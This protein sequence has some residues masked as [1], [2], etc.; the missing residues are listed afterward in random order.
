MPGRRTRSPSPD[1]SRK[2]SKHSTYPRHSPSP[3]RRST[4]HARGHD[5][6]RPRDTRDTRDYE[7]DHRGKDRGKDYDRPREDRNKDRDRRDRSRDRERERPRRSRS[8]SRERRMDIDSRERS[9]PSPRPKSPQS[10]HSVSASANG[11]PGVATPPVAAPPAT[12]LTAEEEAMAIKQAR[13]AAWKRERE[14]KKA[15][16]GAKAKAMALAGKTAA[17]SKP[18]CLHMSLL[19]RLH[20]TW[21]S[22]F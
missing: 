12:P 14:A 17:P 20:I 21:S 16:D 11:T 7:R 2:R 8:R 6:D 5:Y 10:Q 18:L 15:L 19:I 3:T 13:L 22:L 9:K 4:K 1:Y